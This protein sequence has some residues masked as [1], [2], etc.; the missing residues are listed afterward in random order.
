M[1]SKP[2]LPCWAAFVSVAANNAEESGVKWV[3]G[4]PFLGTTGLG[5][6]SVYGVEGSLLS[7]NESK[8]FVCIWRSHV[9]QSLWDALGKL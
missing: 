1:L 6:I 3:V 2:V 7:D 4:N 5:E 8:F 9:V